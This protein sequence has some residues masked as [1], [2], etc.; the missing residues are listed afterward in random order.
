[1]WYNILRNKEFQEQTI[2]NRKEIGYVQIHCGGCVG[3][4]HGNRG[5]GSRHGRN[6]FGESQSGLEYGRERNEKGNET[7]AEA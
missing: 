6:R 5:G 2:N 4:F 1:M 7:A 3:G